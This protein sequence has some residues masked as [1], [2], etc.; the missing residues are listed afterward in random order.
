MQG[1]GTYLK[2]E[3]LKSL[4]K[5]LIYYMLPKNYKSYDRKLLDSLGELIALVVENK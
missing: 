5:L 3:N 2:I 4:R 1:A